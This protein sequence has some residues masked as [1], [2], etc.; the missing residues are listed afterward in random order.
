MMDR[1]N[2]LIAYSAY[3]RKMWRLHDRGK[4]LTYFAWKTSHTFSWLSPISE[5]SCWVILLKLVTALR[6]ASSDSNFS[7][8]AAIVTQD[9]SSACFLL[10]TLKELKFA[11]K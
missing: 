2:F 6:K 3:F 5:I 4:K 1:M 9:S 7:L 11:S 10:P 8:A